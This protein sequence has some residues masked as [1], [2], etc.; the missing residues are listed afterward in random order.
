[1][2]KT[3]LIVEDNAPGMKLFDG[4]IG[5]PGHSP[6]PNPPPQGGRGIFLGFPLPLREGAYPPERIM[7]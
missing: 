2:A 3:V 4:V 6:H 5:S 7:F 1:M